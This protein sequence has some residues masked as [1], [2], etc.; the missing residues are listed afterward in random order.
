MASTARTRPAA[1]PTTAPSAYVAEF[2]GTLLL[3]F[4]IGA[5]ASS[6]S[7][8]GLGFVDFV[9]IAL[10]HA[11]ALTVLVASFGRFSGGHFNPAVTIALLAIKKIKS[12]DAIVYIIAQLLGAVAAAGLLALAFTK[13]IGTIANFGAAGVTKELASGKDG[14]GG[15]FVFEMIGVFILVTTIVATA[16]APGGD[17]RFAP[18]AIGLSLGLANFIAAPFTGGALNPARAFGPALISNSFGET[19][20]FIVVY[21]VAPI[22]GAL[23]AAL[24]Y[25]GLLGPDKDR[26][27]AP[28]TTLSEEN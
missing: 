11:F 10:V 17:R 9:S 25:N 2:V 19:L 28:S 14:I 12:A 1:D 8:G 7:Q 18:L 26:E 13:D 23:L 3:V 27:V 15:G 24:L 5:V 22:V 21:I 4:A 16:V 20:V 6:N